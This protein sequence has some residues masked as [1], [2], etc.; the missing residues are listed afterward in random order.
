MSWLVRRISVHA[1]V[2]LF[3]L[4]LKCLGPGLDASLQ[5]SSQFF[6]D[7]F[8]QSRNPKLQIR[9]L[10]QTEVID[11]ILDFLEDFPKGVGRVRAS[12]QRPD[13]GV[14]LLFQHKQIFHLLLESENSFCK[15]VHVGIQLVAFPDE[16][17]AL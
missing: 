12:L 5:T 6:L 4:A 2:H 17:D 15:P 8:V 9:V 13:V 14:Q 16:S 11:S 1:E 10:L 7:L 3:L